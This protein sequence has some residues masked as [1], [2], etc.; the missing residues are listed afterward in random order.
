MS[1]DQY[2]Q[3]EHHQQHEIRALMPNRFILRPGVAP[4]RFTCRH[5]RHTR[6]SCQGTPPPKQA[7]PQPKSRESAPRPGTAEAKANAEALQRIKYSYQKTLVQMLFAVRSFPDAAAAIQQ[8][9]STAPPHHQPPDTPL[10]DPP[11]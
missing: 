7:P 10:E 3:H 9:L 2:P 5:P 11:Y 1:H 6:C 8:V 4:N